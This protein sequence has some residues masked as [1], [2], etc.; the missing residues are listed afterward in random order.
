MHSNVS[1]IS[2]RR[3]YYPRTYIVQVFYRHILPTFDILPG[4]LSASVCNENN[5]QSLFSL[6]FFLVL[7]FSFAFHLWH[8]GIPII[9]RLMYF[10]LETKS[11]MPPKSGCL[12]SNT[13]HFSAALAVYIKMC[14]VTYM[15]SGTSIPSRAMPFLIIFATFLASTSRVM[16]VCSLSA[17][18]TLKS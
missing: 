5:A 6:S 10:P 12:V 9:P 15:R 13:I 4:C 17:F 8:A 7:F 1:G 16:R 3:F 18:S 14:E 2:Y 11:P